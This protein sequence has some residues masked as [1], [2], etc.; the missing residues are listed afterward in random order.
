MSW[1]T[2]DPGL[3][4][5][6]WAVWRH[7]ELVASGAVKGGEGEWYERAS[8]IADSVAEAAK[9]YDPDQLFY[10]LPQF[11]QSRYEVN[12]SGDLVKLTICAGMIAGRMMQR[13]VIKP[14][15]IIDWKGQLDKK[16]TL[17]RIKVALTKRGSKLAGTTT[18]EADAVGIGLYLLGEF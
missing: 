6:G 18:H 5:T 7:R 13:A 14:I 17:A 3:T 2:I 1:I 9:P 15:R 8:H 10:E 16:L 12:A 11:I 4:G